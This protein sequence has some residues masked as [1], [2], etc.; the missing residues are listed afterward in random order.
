[1]SLV[2]TIF[3]ALL[4]SSKLPLISLSSILF[5]SY[6]LLKRKLKIEARK[7]FK[8][9]GVFIGIVYSLELIKISFL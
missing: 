9:L 2:A 7:T 5:S 1:M 3:L 8:I 4:L 6:F